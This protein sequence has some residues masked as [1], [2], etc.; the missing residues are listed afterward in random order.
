MTK[1]FGQVQVLDDL[2]VT[3]EDDPTPL[4]RVAARLMRLTL[5]HRADVLQEA[6][7][8]RATVSVAS[9]DDAQALTCTFRPGSI[10]LRHGAVTDADA[11]LVVDVA[12][13]LALESEASTGDE[14]LQGLVDRLLHPPVPY[15]R[16]AAQSFWDRTG[17]DRGMPQELVVHCT[18]EE[19]RLVLG[20]GATTYTLSASGADLARVLSGAA[21]LLDS[22][23]SGAVAIRGTLPQLSV[24]AGASNKV[25]FD[26]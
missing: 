6:G 7:R 13:D 21:P 16:D 19:A 25:R 15:W 3:V 11:S 18:D 1:S 2:V 24:M 23:F 9:R 20:D 17:A 8:T 22:V 14:A 12:E 26:V 4:V 10:H 5:L